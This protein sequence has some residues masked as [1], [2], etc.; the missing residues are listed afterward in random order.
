LK[1]YFNIEEAPLSGIVLTFPILDGKVEAWR[2]FCQEL[3]GSQQQ[4]YL[5]SRRRLGITHERMALV[6]TAYGAMAVTTFEG[7]NVERALGQIVTSDL[8][9]DVWYRN[10]LQEMHGIKMAGFEQFAQPVPLS[11]NQEVYFEWALKSDS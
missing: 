1:A 11:E 5:S 6:E 9:F 2:R 8:R 10:R 4:M 3:S 7:S